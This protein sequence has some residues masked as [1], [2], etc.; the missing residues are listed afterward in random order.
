MIIAITKR[1]KCCG[2]VKPLTGF[3]ANA[4]GR[5]GFHSLC[6]LCM[7]A[8]KRDGTARNRARGDARIPESKLCGM[9][10][11][12]L[13]ASEFSRYAPAST[14]LRGYCRDCD[15]VVRRSCK[16]GLTRERV[17]EMLQQGRCDA[18]RRPFAKDSEKHVDHR[19]SDGAVRGVLCERCNTTLGKCEE[20]PEIL[21]SLCGYLDRTRGVDH[22]T[23]PYF[24]TESGVAGI[25]HVGD[26]MSLPPEGT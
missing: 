6:K 2:E 18:C 14:G 23:Q 10:C 24:V 17:L 15:R 25:D 1:C 11:R 20:N 21:M 13:P 16:Y 22:R 7:D 8:K 26:G 19:H 5:M 12:K 4:P 3:Y 9:C